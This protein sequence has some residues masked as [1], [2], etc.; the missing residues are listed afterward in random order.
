M[1]GILKDI[2]VDCGI[3]SASW[4]IEME[5]TVGAQP[6]FIVKTVREFDGNYFGGVV[7]TRAYTAFVPTVQDFVNDLL[8][9]P[10]F[11]AAAKAQQ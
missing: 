2:D 4:M 6:P 10:S 7:V 8:I 11:Q 5:M 9:N 3:V 1:N